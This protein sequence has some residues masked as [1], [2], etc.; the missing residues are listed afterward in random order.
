MRRKKSKPN[1]RKI[2]LRLQDLDHAKASVLNSL[3]SVAR[4]K[5]SREPLHRPS[6]LFAEKFDK[7]LVD[8][9]EQNGQK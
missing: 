7:H 4:A 5:H 8:T 6:F 2:V 1:Y 3:S 9:A